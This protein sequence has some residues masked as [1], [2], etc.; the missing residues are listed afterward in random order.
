MLKSISWQEFLIV[1][2]GI[3][4][5][6][7]AVLAVIYYGHR[8]RSRFS[9]HEQAPEAPTKS[10]TRKSLSLIGQTKEDEGIEDEP[11]EGL[12]STS[13]INVSESARE[14]NLLVGTVADALKELK[15]LFQFIT[16]DQKNKAES[17]DMI[18]TLIERYSQL[19]GTKYQ[20]SINLFIHEN[21]VDQFSFEITLE[22]LQSLWK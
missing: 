12:V 3:A 8:I 17:L 6:Y 4:A 9:D 18:G 22:E 13:D 19:K 10:P 20:H 5:I 16:D 21:A 14:Q 15:N 2:S 11:N 1:L 7:Y